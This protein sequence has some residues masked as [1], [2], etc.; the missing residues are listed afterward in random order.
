MWAGTMRLTDVAHF[1]LMLAA[2]TLTYV[3]PFELLLLE[4]PAGLL[5]LPPLAALLLE[6]LLELLEQAA[7]TMGITAATAMPAT[8]TDCRYAIRSSYSDRDSHQRKGP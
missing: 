2:L 4:L 1:A 7:R 6:L 3:V 5:E 8:R